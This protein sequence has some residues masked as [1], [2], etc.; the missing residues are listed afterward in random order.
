MLPQP[1]ALWVLTAAGNGEIGAHDGL[2]DTPL[3]CTNTLASHRM[4]H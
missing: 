4:H 2:D 3:T 1:G